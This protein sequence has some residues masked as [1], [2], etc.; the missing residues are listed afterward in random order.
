MIDC[1]LYDLIM[2]AEKKVLFGADFQSLTNLSRIYR[3]FIHPGKKLKDELNK[4][5]SDLCF[6][7]AMEIL[8]KII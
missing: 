1:V 2:Y 7:S 3:N 4:A 8:K 6:I 5:K